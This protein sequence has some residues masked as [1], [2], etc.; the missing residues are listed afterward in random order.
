VE[1]ANVPIVASVAAID[2]IERKFGLAAGQRVMKFP[3]VKGTATDP[4][5]DSFQMKAQL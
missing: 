4:G 2:L 1:I 5:A 3:S